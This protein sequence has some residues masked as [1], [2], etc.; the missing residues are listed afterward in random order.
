MIWSNI[1]LGQISDRMR[2]RYEKVDND[3][4]DGIDHSALHKTLVPYS[5]AN[6]YAYRLSSLSRI[7]V[8]YLY[9]G[10]SMCN[11][12]DRGFLPIESQDVMKSAKIMMMK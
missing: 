10:G 11:I 4:G 12:K 8:S 3:C 9:A 1:S 5:R 7:A 2:G 6:R